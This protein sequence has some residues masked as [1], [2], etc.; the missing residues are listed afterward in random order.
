MIPPVRCK[1]TL[2]LAYHSYDVNNAH[3]ERDYG[4]IY[5]KNYDLC[6]K[7]N[8]VSFGYPKQLFKD[9]ED[10]YITAWLWNAQEEKF[11]KDS[12][13][14]LYFADPFRLSIKCEDTVCT[15]L[16]NGVKVT[17]P[18]F[19]IKVQSDWTNVLS[20]KGW[21]EEEISAWAQ[22]KIDD[23][24]PYQAAEWKEAGFTSQNTKKYF[25][26]GITAPETARR[27]IKVCD[28][29]MSSPPYYEFPPKSCF[30][31]SAKAI[32]VYEKENSGLYGFDCNRSGDCNTVYITFG[33]ATSNAH[34]P[35]IFS[36][37]VKPNG[38]YTYTTL[39][40]RTKTI[41]RLM[42]VR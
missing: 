7:T 20:P 30:T 40:G 22:L 2:K 5:S 42:S 8:E 41:P 13:N 23:F 26:M 25:D 11:K 3:D 6:S 27:F 10:G 18:T 32:Q 39:Y 28:D 24:S 34:I 12:M 35:D 16:N 15:L 17:D 29:K 14:G 19:K 33:G 31:L 38:E 36:G 37:I 4:D 21:N 9:S 1:R